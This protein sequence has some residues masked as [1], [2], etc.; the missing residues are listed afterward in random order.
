MVC[1]IPDHILVYLC[2]LLTSRLFWGHLQ[3]I[4]Y[5]YTSHES[6]NSTLKLTPIFPGVQWFMGRMN[7]SICWCFWSLYK[8]DVCIYF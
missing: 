8:M 1:L 3:L 6:R 7:V 5:L 4:Y 2:L